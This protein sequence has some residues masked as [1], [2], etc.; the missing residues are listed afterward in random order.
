MTDKGVFEFTNDNKDII[1]CWVGESGSLF[2]F[3]QIN[4]NATKGIYQ[5]PVYN[6]VSIVTK[7]IE[8]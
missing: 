3:Y 1:P 7:E 4:D 6:V 2:F 5:F 8:K